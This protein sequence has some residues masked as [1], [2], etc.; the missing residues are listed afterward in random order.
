MHLASSFMPIPKGDQNS[1]SGAV[2]KLA[3]EPLPPERAVQRII[4]ATTNE[5][6]AVEDRGLDGST[7]LM[8]SVGEL[9][10]TRLM[11]LQWYMIVQNGSD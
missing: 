4:M 7:R 3:E 8:D 10:C 1:Q 6:R 5:M 11:H 2:I 9:A